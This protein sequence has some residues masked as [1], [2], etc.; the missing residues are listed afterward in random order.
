MGGSPLPA[1][2]RVLLIDDFAPFRQLL[3]HLIAERSYEVV[4]HGTSGHDAVRLATEVSPDLVLLDIAM[5]GMNGIDAAEQI[6]AVAP[7][8][9]ILLVTEQASAEYVDSGLRFANGY[10]LKR[11]L[12]DE[13]LPAIDAVLAGRRY[14]SSFVLPSEEE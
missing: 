11:N 5:P 8:V 12:V 7:H 3:E 9:K 4:G 10:V 6:R 1:I 13:L 2:L 14:V